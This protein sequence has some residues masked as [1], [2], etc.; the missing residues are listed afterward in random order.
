M[1][2]QLCRLQL[3]GATQQLKSKAKRFE[4]DV[5]PGVWWKVGVS[6]VLISPYLP[7]TKSHSTESI[8]VYT[9][10]NPYFSSF[11]V[12]NPKHSDFVKLRTMLMYVKILLR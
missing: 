1:S 10:F 4:E 2:R 5:T 9:P 7:R 6:V 11:S 3:W 8:S 12:E